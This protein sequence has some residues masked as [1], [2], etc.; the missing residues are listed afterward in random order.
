MAAINEEKKM[1]IKNTFRVFG[2]FTPNRTQAG[3]VTWTLLPEFR[4]TLNQRRT[5]EVTWAWLPGFGIT[6]NCLT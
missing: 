3:Q 4:M 1:P 5:S 6:P 2:W